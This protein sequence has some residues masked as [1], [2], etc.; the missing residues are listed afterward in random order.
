M[1]YDITDFYTQEEKTMLSRCMLCPHECGVNRLEGEKGYCQSDAE[2]NIAL[3]CNHKGE[4][5]VLSGEKGIC[6]VFFSHCNC[7]CLF[8]QNKDISDNRKKCKNNYKTLKEAA[9]KIEEILQESENIV[10]FVSPTHQIPMMKSIIRELHRRN[11]HPKIVYNT[12]GYDK[13]E[14]IK[15]L[16]GIVDIYLPDFKYA[17]KDLALRFSKI[18]NYPQVCLQAVKEM[19]RQTG[20]SILSDERER[21]LRGLI[22]RH[23]ILPGHAEES[24]EVLENIAFELSFSVSISLMGQYFP[25]FEIKDYPELNRTLTKE[26]YQEV[27]EHFHALGLHNGWLQDISSNAEYLPD[28]EN[29]GFK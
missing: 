11:L 7:Q 14:E 10:G 17:N 20:S 4:E 12:S 1:N 19:Y 3:I 27:A 6:N 21:A 5:P 18:K 24:K 13:V 29:M 9:D 22:I 16:E 15:G 23:L 25:P 8:C 2:L 28:F 26:E